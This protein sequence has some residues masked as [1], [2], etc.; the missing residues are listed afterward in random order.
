[1]SYVGLSQKEERRMLAAIGT[2]SFES[3]IESIPQEVR[4]KERLATTYRRQRC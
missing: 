4:R 1:M 2:D 3:L